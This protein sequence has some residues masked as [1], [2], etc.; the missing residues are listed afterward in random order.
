MGLAA[1]TSL[2]G[3]SLRIGDTDLVEVTGL[4]IVSIAAPLPAPG[5][6][7][8]VT[9]DTLNR[10]VEQH[11]G[12][13]L[14]A[15]GRLHRCGDTQAILGLQNSQW[16]VTA[17]PSTHD[18]ASAL[19]R[20]LGDA[21]YLTDQSDSWAVLDLTGP[22]AQAA[23][24]R[25]C[26]LD[27]DPAVFDDTCVSRTVMEHVSVIVERPEVTHFRLYCSRSAAQSFLHALSESLQIVCE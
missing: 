2:D 20:V 17:T 14:P 6:A 23:L 27:L 8:G 19:K 25:L 4:D 15:V 10:L 5:H 12:S 24:E 3:L 18:P 22:L 1:T 26:M 9:A 13:S 16:F 21:A 11:L 7:Q